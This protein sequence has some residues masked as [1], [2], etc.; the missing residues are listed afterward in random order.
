[1]LSAQ[2]RLRPEEDSGYVFQHCTVT[3]D[4]GAKEVLLGRPWR[5]YSTVVWIDT[6]FKVKI[7]SK[8]WGE[9]D[10]RLA[11]SDYAEFNSH[12]MV[13]DISQR[14]A[15]SKQLS[16]ADAAK[17]ST[18]VWLAGKDGWNPETLH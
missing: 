6:D 9:W 14:V 3:G 17:Y 10:G 4:S 12:G 8:G 2:S 13:S 18:R 11:T 16:A 1:M 7:D 5:A 15:P